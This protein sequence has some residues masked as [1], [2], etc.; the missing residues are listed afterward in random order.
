MRPLRE[1]GKEEN[2]HEKEKEIAPCFKE[3][4]CVKCGKTKNAYLEFYP[5]S[6]ICKECAK[7]RMHDYRRRN[8]GT[9]KKINFGIYHENY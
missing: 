6:R 8:Y 3:R 2:A 9:G 1:D 5:G 4:Q 7:K